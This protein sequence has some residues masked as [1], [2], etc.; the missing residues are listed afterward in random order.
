MGNFFSGTRGQ[1]LLPS[2]SAPGGGTLGQGVAA[3]GADTRACAW[4]KEEAAAE[5]HLEEADVRGRRARPCEQSGAAASTREEASRPAPSALG[6]QGS[7]EFNS[8]A[9]AHGELHF[10]DGSWT[11]RQTLL[12]E[13]RDRLLFSRWKTGT[14]SGVTWLDSR[15]PP[16]A[17]V[18]GRHS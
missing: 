17:L 10:T 5:A 13:A 6:P 14:S 7:L 15:S 8:M 11:P 3:E 1:L 4:R 18:P 2:N 9:D 16:K 12:P